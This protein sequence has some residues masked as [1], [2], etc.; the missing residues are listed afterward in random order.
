MT[1]RELPAKQ[2][3]VPESELPCKSMLFPRSWALTEP[4]ARYAQ[5]SGK[6]LARI[7]R[8]D[9]HGEWQETSRFAS[10]AWTGIP[11][12]TFC[13][14]SGVWSPHVLIGPKPQ[15]S[16][17]NGQDRHEY[18]ALPPLYV[19]L[20]KTPEQCAWEWLIASA[21]GGSGRRTILWTGPTVGHPVASM[22]KWASRMAK[23]HK[24]FAV[25]VKYISDHP[26][27]NKVAALPVCVSAGKRG[28]WGAKKAST[29]TNPNSGRVCAVYSAVLPLPMPTFPNYRHNPDLVPGVLGLGDT[30]VE[31]LGDILGWRRPSMPRGDRSWLVSGVRMWHVIPENYMR[32]VYENLVSYRKCAMPDRDGDF[33]RA[34]KS[35]AELLGAG[36]A[37]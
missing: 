7:V 18:E 35:L 29:S 4:S 37:N 6:G 25:N 14:G 21:A 11:Y 16:D 15:K 12:P 36:P 26:E 27:R 5:T 20:E 3:H 23:E 2:S 30:E 1:D 31:Q 19:P 8:Q 34:E 33:R 32:Y 24:P 10:I 17:W 28:Q 22:Y 9:E 13:G